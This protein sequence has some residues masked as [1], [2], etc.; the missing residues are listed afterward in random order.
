[1]MKKILA[2]VT[3][4]ALLFGALFTLGAADDLTGHWAGTEI[5][6]MEALGV[7]A[8][9]GEDYEPTRVV[10]RGEFVKMLLTAAGYTAEGENIRSART[11][12]RDVGRDHEYNGYMT[13]AVELG[14]I[15]AEPG[16]FVYPDAPMTRAQG[17]GMVL[18]LMENLGD[19]TYPVSN[20]SDRESLTEEEGHVADGAAHLGIL[21]FEN[22]EVNAFTPGA[23]LTRAEALVMIHNYLR[24][25]GRLYDYIGSVTGVGEGT[26]EALVLGKNTT[27]LTYEGTL[28]VPPVGSRVGFI[29]DNAGRLVDYDVLER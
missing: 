17:A 2:L 27:F 18:T 9:T 12:F 11:N 4:T 20:F 5:R 24:S 13:L 23:E 14:L 19:M 16:D 10:T 6:R 28:R 25:L 26:I 21:Y 29:L 15:E 8:R 7:F 22:S 1:M 3:I